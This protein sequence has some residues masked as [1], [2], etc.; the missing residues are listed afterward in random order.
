[1]STS[2]KK[3]LNYDF[4]L[5]RGHMH[6]LFPDLDFSSLYASEFVANFFFKKGSN[7]IHTY[8]WKYP[9]KTFKGNFRSFQAGSLGVRGERGYLL[10]LYKEVS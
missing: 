10:S 3:I 4:M 1:M 2:L 5:F 8:L 9:C 7:K 6:A